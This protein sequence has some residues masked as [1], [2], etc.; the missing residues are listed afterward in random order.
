MKIQYDKRTIKILG[1]IMLLSALW[2]LTGWATLFFELDFFEFELTGIFAIGG[3]VMGGVLFLY[4]LAQLVE[5]LGYIRRLK[6]HGYEVPYNKRDY[7]NS[8]HKLPCLGDGTIAEGKSKESLALCILF[9]CVFM[10]S[11]IWNAYYAIH[12]YGYLEEN[13]LFLTKVLIFLDLFWMIMAIV[14][15]FQRN[16]KKYRDDVDKDLKRKVRMSLERGI[17]TCVIVLIIVSYVKCIVVEMS[18]YVYRSRMDSDQTYLVQ[19][20]N[21]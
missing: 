11:N 16:N 8:L 12:W 13:A 4:S 9:W 17:V 2:N 21:A 19:I 3:I 5:G 20:Q 6:A 1:M 7:G 18:E 10:F 14:F 15:F